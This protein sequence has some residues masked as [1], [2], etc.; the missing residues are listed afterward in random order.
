MRLLGLKQVQESEDGDDL[1]RIIQMLQH[2]IAM[3]TLVQLNTFNV[4]VLRIN[5]HVCKYLFRSLGTSPAYE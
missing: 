5:M 3:T 4:Q 2:S 1:Y